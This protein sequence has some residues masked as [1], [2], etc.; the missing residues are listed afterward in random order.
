[1]LSQAFW[2]RQVANCSTKDYCHHK[3]LALSMI[4]GK[5]SMTLHRQ[6]FLGHGSEVVVSIIVSK[7]SQ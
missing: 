7:G 6:L 2:P 1:M 5:Q 3:A 4:Q